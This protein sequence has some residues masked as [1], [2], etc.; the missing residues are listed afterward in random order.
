MS[1]PRKRPESSSL[2]K[3]ADRALTRAAR[4][5]RE[6]ARLYGTPIYVSRRGKVTS[7]KP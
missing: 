4:R 5:A 6:T 3:S 7:L 1:K 2:T